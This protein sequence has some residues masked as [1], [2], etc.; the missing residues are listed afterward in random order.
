MNNTLNIFGGLIIGS[1]VFLTIINY[2]ASNIE[3]FE[4][5]PL[6]Q[7]K[8]MTLTT[9]NPTLRIEATSRSKWT[10][11]DF[12]TKKTYIIKDLEKEKTKLK[13]FPWDIGF[14]R[15]KIITNGGLTNPEG[16]VGLKNMGPI[17]FDSLAN[18]PDTGYIQDAK[19]YGKIINKAIADWYLYR[20]RTHN[21]ESQK[22]VY[23][24]RMAEG[25]YLKMRILNYYC[26]RDESECRTIMC[27]RQEAACY[28]IEYV[29][30]TDSG[31][32][33][34]IPVVAQPDPIEI[35]IGN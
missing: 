21:I 19:S 23:V 35:G 26:S 20:T 31:R 18:V 7:P 29:L 6:P 15:T 9:K 27:L 2:M 25:G 8:Q 1:I 10:L 11:V 17:D 28:S 30:P 32:R 34:P 22:N 4:S 3:D 16:M 13:S 12:S 24:L 33:F 14:Q 5:V